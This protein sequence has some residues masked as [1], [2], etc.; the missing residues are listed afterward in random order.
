M[1]YDVLGPKVFDYLPCTYGASKLVFRGPKQRLEDP[2]VAFVGGT[3][4][5]G[6]FIE[7]PFPLRVEHLTGVTSVNFGQVA[8]GVD[9]FLRDPVVLEAA[10][11]A[12]VTVLEVLGAAHVSNPL[13]KVHGRRN[14]RFLG[15][16][17]S[18]KLLYPDVDFTEFSFVQH[19]L[20]HLYQV[21]PQRFA[22]VKHQLQRVWLRRM[23]RLVRRLGE[24]VVLV[25]FV[26]GGPHGA[27]AGWITQA[28]AGATFVTEA[29]I[30][31]LGAYTA[32]V[33][34]V[35]MKL[36]DAAA[37]GLVYGAHEAEAARVVAGPSAHQT[38]ANRLRRV[39]DGLM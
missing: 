20:G 21:D 22:L 28:G 5:F 33:V 26:A 39:L 13:Y 11:A 7:Q 2:Y 19:M 8:A 23:K 14:D 15:P 6:K 24:P 31:Q 16:S 17:A 38:A 34:G 3:Q 1:T 35:E 29:M 32:A 12:R 10:Q 4:T 9:V 36:D 37:G 27:E 30:D 25:H 18:L